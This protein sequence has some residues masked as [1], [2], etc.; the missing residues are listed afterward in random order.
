MLKEVTL[1][2]GGIITEKTTM[3]ELVALN[4]IMP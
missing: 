3:I 4:K 1:A 2:E